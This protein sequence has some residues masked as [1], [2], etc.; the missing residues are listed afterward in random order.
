MTIREAV[1]RAIGFLTNRKQVYQQT[2]CNPIGE[3]VLGDL[4]PF[5]RANETCVVPGD[6]VKTAIL[7]GRRE[8]WLRIQQHINYSPEQ[9][10]ALY[11]R[12]DMEKISN[13]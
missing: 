3:R 7:E 4:A 11:A 9:L 5:C 2:F 8:V 12:R 13:E 10:F 6:P 1:D